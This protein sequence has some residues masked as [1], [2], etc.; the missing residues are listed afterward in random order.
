[1]DSRLVEIVNNLE[2]EAESLIQEAKAK[3]SSE[4]AASAEATSGAVQ[5]IR[6]EALAE[7]EN[8]RTGAR[9]EL[10]KELSEARITSR[11]NLEQQIQQANT[12]L[13]KAVQVILHRLG[14]T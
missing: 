10:E 4:R 5:K 1:V 3:A 14:R 7:A 13:Q 2:L 6:A 12:K 8:I 9:A 11:S